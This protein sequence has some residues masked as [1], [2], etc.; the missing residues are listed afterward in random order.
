[1]QELPDNRRSHLY[2]KAE[3]AYSVQNT[4]ITYFG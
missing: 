1:M 3:V 2:N 4:V